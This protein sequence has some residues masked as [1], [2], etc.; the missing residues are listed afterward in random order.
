[1]PVGFYPTSLEQRNSNLLCDMLF[2]QDYWQLYA[3]IPIESSQKQ[4]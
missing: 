2:S 4:Y 1:M 3:R